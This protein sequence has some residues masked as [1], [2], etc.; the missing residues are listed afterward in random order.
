[1]RIFMF[2]GNPKLRF[3][4]YEKAL[5]RIFWSVSKFLKSKICVT[6]TK[7]F[8]PVPLKGKRDFLLEVPSSRHGGPWRLQGAIPGYLR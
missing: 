7:K 3:D 1:M 5:L 8:N 4:Q 2:S 6:I